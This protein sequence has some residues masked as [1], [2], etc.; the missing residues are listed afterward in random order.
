MHSFAPFWNRIPK[1]VDS[2]PPKNLAQLNLSQRAGLR[3]HAD[4]Q[5]PLR[6][7]LRLHG[8]LAVDARVHADRVGHVRWAACIGFK[9]LF[10]Q[11]IAQHLATSFS[12][13]CAN[14]HLMLT[15]FDR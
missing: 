7:R 8:V 10:C 5:V 9:W 1:T 13:S 2:I 4:E 14:I 6:P 12:N 15:D 11:N 3:R